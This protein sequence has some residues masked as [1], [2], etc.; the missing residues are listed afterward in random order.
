[1]AL[2]RFREDHDE[3]EWHHCHLLLGR[4][5]VYWVDDQPGAAYSDCLQLE[6]KLVGHPPQKV[7]PL[8]R[9]MNLIRL[10][11][12]YK[13]RLFT[14][15][16]RHLTVCEIRGVHSSVL[17]PY[18]EALKIR[19]EEMNGNLENL[20]NDPELSPSVGASYVG[21]IQVVFDP[22]KGRKIVTTRAVRSGEIL[23]SEPPVVSL[24]FDGSPGVMCST[25]KWGQQ[26]FKASPH[27][28]SWIMH[29]IMDDPSIGQFVHALA[30]NANLESQNLGLTD[31]ERMEVF[32]NPCEI[33]VDLLE[34]QINRNSFG[35]NNMY[36]LYGL[37][38]MISHSC[39]P[40]IFKGGEE[41]RRNVKCR[42]TA[43]GLLDAVLQSHE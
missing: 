7:M 21:P 14:M 40:N 18:R 43:N 5:L 20:N 34:Q 39:K 24:K 10:Q 16:N 11:A 42:Y 9:K 31:D 15:A 41:V 1:M 4:A 23:L 13:L 29:Q 8:W 28:V 38:S 35:E 36:S 6:R 3:N 12:A 25:I 33:E 30:P 22:V 32:R 19:K 27:H 2:A 26:T 37:V 17:S